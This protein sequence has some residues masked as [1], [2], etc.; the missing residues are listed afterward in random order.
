MAPTSVYWALILADLHVN[1]LQV[2]TS[3]FCW[4]GGSA[5]GGS[6]GPSR[7]GGFGIGGTGGKGGHA[8]GGVS[9]L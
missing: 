5:N 9:G 3:M 7:A 8:F 2:L 1:R 4:Y 6:S